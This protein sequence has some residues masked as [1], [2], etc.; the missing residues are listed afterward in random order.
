[1]IVV[2]DNGRSY[3][4]TVGGLANHLTTLRTNPRYEQVLDMVKRRLNGVRG[5]GPAVYDALHAMK[6][7]MKDALAPQGLFEDLGLKYVGPIDG[8]DRAAVEQALAQAKRFNGPVIVHVITRKGFGY[9]PAERHEAD[10]FH[11]PGPF[12][13]ETGE[14]NPK[15]Q[16]WTDVFADEMVTLGAERKD[17]VAITAAMMHPVGLH[18]FAAKYPE[19]TFDVGIAEQHA[20][21]SAAGPRDGRA[22]PGGRGLR[23]VPQPR[24]RP[25]ADGRRPAQVRRH[26]RPRP[27]RR[28]RRRRRLPQRH[29]GHVHPPGRAGP[30]ARGAA[31]RHPAA[32]AA[33]RGGPGRR[34]PDRRALPEGPAQRGPRAPSAGR[35]AAT[36]SSA[37]APRTC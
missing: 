27:L 19:R 14:E 18:L 5:V 10:Q 15:G 28:D 23:D 37:T 33:A 36:C 30:P 17:L 4:P 32:R 1:M 21:T 9:D 35:A 26:L 31:G 6:K 34:R 25:G 3:T 7:G 13:A 20:A 22:A 16:I 8:H 11:G 29:V 2:N 24:L 12:N